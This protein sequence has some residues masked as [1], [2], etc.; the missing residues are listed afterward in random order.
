MDGEVGSS[1]VTDGGGAG[2]KKPRRLKTVSD[3]EMVG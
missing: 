3:L 1:H 2:N